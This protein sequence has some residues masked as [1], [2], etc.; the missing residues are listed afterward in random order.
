M[1][2]NIKLTVCIAALCDARRSLILATDQMLDY[3]D[4]SGDAQILKISSLNSRWAAMFSG[5]DISQIQP[6]LRDSRTRLE[7]LGAVSLEDA[8]RAVVSALQARVRELQTRILFRY[9]FDTFESFKDTGLTSLGDEYFTKIVG[10]LEGVRLGFEFL[11]TGFDADGN[12]HL[13]TVSDL[14]STHHYDMVG[15][16]AI[17]S[18][19]TAVHNTL[20][21]HSFNNRMPFEQALYYV[22]AGKFMS[23]R[24]GGVGETTTVIVG[25][26]VDGEIRWQDLSDEMVDELRKRWTKDGQ[27]RIPRGMGPYIREQKDNH[28]SFRRVIFR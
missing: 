11:I 13:F 17:G 5:E 15:F 21:F 9:G 27:P 25:Q 18:G 1:Q 20:S 3:G 8:E 19:T 16:A 24:A 12:P 2:R 22:C 7:A 28:H 6:V 10:Q 14:G 23:E 4:Y 26:S